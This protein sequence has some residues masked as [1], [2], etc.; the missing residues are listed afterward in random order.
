ME[1]QILLVVWGDP[2]SSL[3]FHVG[4]LINYDSEYIFEYTHHNSLANRRLHDAI[5]HGFYAYP[6]FPDLY[7][8]YKSKELFPIFNRRIPS[9]NRSDYNYILGELSLPKSADKVDLLKA[10][11]G[12][13]AG[14][15]YL[16]GEPLG[17]DDK[18]VL[19]NHF[20]IN[21]MRYVEDLPVNCFEKYK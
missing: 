3:Y 2:N 17:L 18:G 9:P 15:P 13:P 14:D 19:N 1:K 4:K 20:Y 7:K 6:R 12:A 5:N 16:F 8:K 21:G 10:T 11:R